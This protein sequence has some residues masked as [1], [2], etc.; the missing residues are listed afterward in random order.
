MFEHDFDAIN[1]VFDEYQGDFSAGDYGVA[2]GSP[3]EPRGL[4]SGSSSGNPQ[5]CPQTQASN[6]Q[7]CKLQDL[8]KD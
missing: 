6:I 4:Q 5:G 3:M 8:R 7:A 2:R 1:S